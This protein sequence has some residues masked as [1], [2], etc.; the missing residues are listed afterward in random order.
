M[1]RLAM[2]AAV[3]VTLLGCSDKWTYEKTGRAVIHD[4]TPYYVYAMKAEVTNTHG[5][6]PKVTTAEVVR[7]GQ[8]FY[9][10]E[11]NCEKA[12]F[13]QLAK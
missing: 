11:P 3:A 10:C 6:L 4:G 1:T 9:Q 5:G 2:L 12:V 13:R 8:S 7:V